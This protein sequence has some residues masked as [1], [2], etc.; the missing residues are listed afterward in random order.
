MVIQQWN[1]NAA[2]AA[3]AAVAV[4]ANG[5]GGAGEECDHFSFDDSD[6]FEEDSICTWSSEPESMCNNWRGWRK[7]TASTTNGGATGNGGN[8]SNTFMGISLGTSNSNGGSSSG[9]A[10]GGNIS[11]DHRIGERTRTRTEDNGK[12]GCHEV[13]FSF[14]HLDSFLLQP[15]PIRQ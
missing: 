3:A 13:S 6:R 5:G 10:L 12:S 9:A 14:T 7:P 2:V 15:S 11:G 4:A 8:T 1:N